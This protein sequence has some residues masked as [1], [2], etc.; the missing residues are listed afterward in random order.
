MELL[1]T[2]EHGEHLS[3][4]PPR[5]VTGANKPLAR[6]LHEGVGS[7]FGTRDE[8]VAAGIGG[9]SP[10]TDWC[11]SLIGAPIRGTRRV[12]GAI[13]AREPRA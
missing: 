2:I 3:K 9:A 10:G 8:Q 13:V 6:L 7:Y 5:P 1:Y 4:G 11:L 12:L